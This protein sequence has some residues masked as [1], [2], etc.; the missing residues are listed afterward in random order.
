MSFV[1]LTRATEERFPPTRGSAMRNDVMSP[2]EAGEFSDLIREMR[3]ERQVARAARQRA[4]AARRKAFVRS[5]P[6]SFALLLQAR[7]RA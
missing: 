2:A 3:W 7:N 5:I 6:E 4:A 1:V